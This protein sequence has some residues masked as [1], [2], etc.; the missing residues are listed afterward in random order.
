MNTRDSSAEEFAAVVKECGVN[1]V[2]PPAEAFNDIKYLSSSG[3]FVFGSPLEGSSKNRHCMYIFETGT[4]NK[5]DWSVAFNLWTDE[6]GRSDFTLEL[7][8]TDLAEGKFA[9][10][11]DDLRFQQGNPMQHSLKI[12]FALVTAVALTTFLDRTIAAEPHTKL[13]SIQLF[14]RMRALMDVGAAIHQYSLLLS[15][16]GFRK[17]DHHF[18]KGNVI[19]FGQGARMIWRL[20][21]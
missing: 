10:T 8:G 16:T 15:E 21:S 2:I 19:F 1:I 6:D 4:N 7:S 11:I 14:D 18:S 13:S 17:R 3:A 20:E 9:I 5:F 12:R